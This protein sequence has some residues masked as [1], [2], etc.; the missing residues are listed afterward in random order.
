MIKVLQKQ[1][2]DRV[3]EIWLECNRKAHAFIPADY[4]R[5][6]FDMVKAMLPQAEVYVYE[7]DNSIQG[8]AGL[9]GDYIEGFFVSSECQCCGIGARLL[10]HIKWIRTTLQLKVYQKNTRAIRFYL[11]EGFEILSEGVDEATG[12]KEYVMTWPDS[13]SCARVRSMIARS[14]QTR[15]QIS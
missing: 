13:R 6:N 9:S 11:R 2:I 5:Q 12:E 4:W 10:N 7:N 1:D 15:S 3:A 8:F 14:V